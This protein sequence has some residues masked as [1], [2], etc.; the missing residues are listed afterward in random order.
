M[1]HWN[2]RQ[3]TERLWLVATLLAVLATPVA[4]AGEEAGR[5]SMMPADGGVIRLD[6]ETGAM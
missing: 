2:G 5:Y 4:A 3:G 1:E 6:R